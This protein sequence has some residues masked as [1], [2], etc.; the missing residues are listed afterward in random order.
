M[1]LIWQ[2]ICLSTF[3]AMCW[4][5]GDILL[6]SLLGKNVTLPQL[7]RHSLAFAIGNVVISYLLTALGFIGGFIPTVL[8]TVFFTGVGIT[9]LHLIGKFRRN[10]GSRL[11]NQTIQEETNK[12]F[13]KERREENKANIF[14]IIIMGIFFFPAFL[15]AASPPYLR[16]SLVYHLL[17]PKEYLKMGHLVTIEGNLYSAFPKGHEVL[18]TL[19]LSIG[20]DRAAQGFSILQQISAIGELYSLTRFMAGPLTASLCTIGYATVPSVM[21]FTG[22]GYVEPALLMTLA[23]SLLVLFLYLRSV[24]E[25]IMSGSMGLKLISL[26]GFLAGWMPSLKYSG[27]IYLGLFGLILLWSQRRVL[28]K[29]ALSMIGVFSLAAA[30]GFCWMGWNWTTLGNPVYPMGW[31]I[32]GGKNWDEARAL[33]MS[34]YFDAYGMGRNLLDY[35]LLM[36]R[37]AFSGRFDTIR[38]DGAMGPFLLLFLALAAVSAY[39]LIRRRM[40]EDMMKIIGFMFMI[41]TAFFIFGTQQTRFWLPSQMLVCIFS[42]PSVNLLLK[43]VGSKRIIKSAL[44]LILFGSLAWNL[45]FLGKQFFAVGYYKPVLGMEE[46]RDFLRRKVP[47]YP[48]LEFIN[49]NLPEHSYTFCV[50]TGAY[51]YYLNRK[52]Y[53]E[54]FIEDVTLKKFMEGCA[55]GKELSR[56]LSGAGFTHVFL[57]ISL[58]EK[59]M[60]AEQRSIFEDFLKNEV[61]LIFGEHDFC[62]FEIRSERR[63]I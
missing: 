56:K 38:F 11:F 12:G 16:D 54:T 29:K 3:G 4:A 14:L 21:Y 62:L 43:W 53:S 8:W 40:N 9:I 37:L 28:L 15:Q 50:W 33:A 25:T 48:V 55:S 42:A 2:F 39:L 1:N 6:Q 18:M 31:F 27:L 57:R 7:V 5:T 34:L 10:S 63:P 41:S 47:G 46:E 49:E 45:W 59:N 22:C 13:L 35:L 60:K 51:G 26:V 17:C 32:F 19:L 36:W 61:R 52:Y 20:G 44:F 30:P 24:R 58:T 23:G